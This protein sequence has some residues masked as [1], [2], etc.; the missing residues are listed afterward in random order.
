MSLSITSDRTTSDALTSW[1]TQL[2]VSLYL[3]IASVALS[4]ALLAAEIDWLG[5]NGAWG[6]SANWPN[7]I[8]PTNED[9]VTLPSGVTVTSSGST[10]IAEELLT[11]ARLSVLD[12]LFTVV[13]TIDAFDDFVISPN[14]AVSAGRIFTQPDGLLDLQANASVN[15]IEGVFN[16]GLVDIHDAAVLNAESFD[17]FNLWDVRAGGAAI[18]NSMINHTGA[19]I[20]VV[21]SATVFDI[22]G[23]LTNDGSL[24]ID[25]AASGQVDSIE[26]YGVIAV[27]GGAQLIGNSVDNYDSV[28]ISGAM[29]EWH[30]GITTNF[31]GAISISGGASGESGTVDNRSDISIDDAALSIDDGVNTADGL[32]NLS[33]NATAEVAN[34]LSNF[35]QVNIDSSSHLLSTNFQQLAGETALNGGTLGA[36]DTS[37]TSISGGALIGRGAVN[38]DLSVTNAGLLA[39]DGGALDPTAQLAVSGD[40][41]LGGTFAVDLGGLANNDFDRLLVAGEAILGGTLSVDLVGGLTPML[42]DFFDIITAQ[43]VDGD[44]DSLLLPILGNG[45]ALEGLNGGSFYRL[46]IVAAP[47]PIPG[48]IPMFVAILLGLGFRRRTP[49]VYSL[50]RPA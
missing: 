18:A 9:F 31:S 19:V 44:F 16:Y 12:G 24:N 1:L 43:N 41:L 7:G 20:D 23:N 39:P 11:R 8:F 34:L 26:N 48:V 49:R 5:G 4:P 17:N 10:N 38:G 37:I 3:V 36:N 2:T 29:S 42:G 50:T 22:N 27:S 45:L 40:L 28:A 13:G 14:A 32:L 21:Q 15:V 46:Q 33:N 25:T 30:A 35:G 6:D 47:V